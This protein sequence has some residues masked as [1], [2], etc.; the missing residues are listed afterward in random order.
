M[1]IPKV[2]SSSLSLLVSWRLLTP[3]IDEVEVVSLTYVEVTVETVDT[4][5]ISA[6]SV[7][8]VLSP[9]RLGGWSS[10]VTVP[11][12]EISR[13]GKLTTPSGIWSSGTVTADAFS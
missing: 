13:R 3:L 7:T 9:R 4:G 11:P 5:G 2:I 6:P 10:S 12:R 8:E 1:E